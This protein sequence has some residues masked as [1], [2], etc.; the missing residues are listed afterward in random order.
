[1]SIE[2]QDSQQTTCNATALIDGERVQVAS[3]TCSIRPDKG[4]NISVDVMEAYSGLPDADKAE[5]AAMFAEY[6][7]D[8]IDK[9]AGLGIPV[10]TPVG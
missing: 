2:R 4:M 9:A 1:M 8:E 10:E 7:A 5:I 3:A 6:L